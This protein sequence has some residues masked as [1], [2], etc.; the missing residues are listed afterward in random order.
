MVT[1]PLQEKKNLDFGRKGSRLGNYGTFFLKGNEFIL[2]SYIPRLFSLS[3]MILSYSFTNNFGMP[4]IVNE[5]ESLKGSFWW[6][7]QT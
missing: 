3:I 4:S 7:R 1:K 2:L 6:V 5:S